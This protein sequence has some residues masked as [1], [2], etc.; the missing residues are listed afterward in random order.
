MKNVISFINLTQFFFFQLSCLC[1]F[2]IN[3]K[4]KVQIK[5]Q[6]FIF[7]KKNFFLYLYAFRRFYMCLHFETS[8]Q[9]S[10]KNLDEPIFFIFKKSEVKNMNNKFI[11]NKEIAN[12]VLAYMNENGLSNNKM[13]EKMNTAMELDGLKPNAFNKDSFG[14]FVLGQKSPNLEQLQALAL[15]MGCTVGSLIDAK[16]D[17][18][19]LRRVINQAIHILKSV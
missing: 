15:V 3:V 19:E 9:I 7:I 6:K 5:T 4:Y 1:A 8:V 14:K 17:E 10:S 13:V 2:F 12:I 11:T 16:P 18:D